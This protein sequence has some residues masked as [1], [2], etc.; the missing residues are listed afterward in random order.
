M[1]PMKQRFV[2]AVAGQLTGAPH[3]TAKDE[4]IEELSD[5]LYR[6]YQ[7]LVGAG[8]GQ[9]DAWRQAMD[10]L[11]DTG[12]LV[13]YLNGL[14][15]DES[16]PEP[17]A[18]PGQGDGG[19]MEELLR[20]VEEMV[21][22]ALG[23]AKSALKDAKDRA[24]DSLGVSTDELAREAKEKVGQAFR[25]AKDALEGTVSAWAGGRGE[26]EAPDPVP[27]D[28]PVWANKLTGL[29][30]QVA[31]DVTIRLNQGEDG[32]VVIG[33]DVGR[34]EAFRTEDGVLTIRQDSRT[35]SSFFLFR[36]GL[37]AADV[38]LDLPRRWWDFIRVS[39]AAGD[40]EVSGDVPLGQLTIQT[41]S[42]DLCGRLPQCQQLE[43]RSTS[44][45]VEWEGCVDTLRVET[46]SGDV[47]L[48]GQLSRVDQMVCKSVSGDIEWEGAAGQ[49]QAETVS[50][51]I[52]LSGRMGQVQAS[53]TSGEVELTGQVEQPRCSSASGGVR[54][55]S[56]QLPRRMEL[57]SKSGD[58]EARIPDD[59]AFLLHFKTASGRIQ[60]DFFPDAKGGRSST[61]SYR[62]DEAAG[63]EVPVYRI[64]S[65]SGDL[66]LYQY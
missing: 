2:N 1:E 12:E 63:Q 65:I 9:E 64:S 43:V 52:L 59:G 25:K 30:V 61:F 23:K 27:L 6:R 48:R 35:A 57:S 7:D 46:V 21:K 49:L 24:E 36:R 34:L 41:A 31:G 47:H 4:L 29:D 15:P 11:G 20:N 38:T 54:L 51:D 66:H 13:E 3:S 33:G 26:E 60:S 58:C 17:V 19:Q 8:L 42:G 53:S 18:R 56:G 50:G 14:Q 62:R 16:L 22:G 39:T 10:C 32:D 44:G 40:V 55:E 37:Y 5:N 28:G 45:D